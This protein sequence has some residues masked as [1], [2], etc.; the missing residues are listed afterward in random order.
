M[1]TLQRFRLD[2]GFCVPNSGLLLPSTSRGY[3]LTRESWIVG[4]MILLTTV[5]DFPYPGFHL[6]AALVLAGMWLE[7]TEGISRFLS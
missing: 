4:K 1:L 7:F 2:P 5:E 6:R 3:W